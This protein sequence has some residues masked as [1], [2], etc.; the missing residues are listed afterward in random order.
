MDGLRRPEVLEHQA[1]VVPVEEVPEELQD[2]VLVQAVR[3]VQLLQHLQLPDAG[4]AP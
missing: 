3:L 4:F 1:E 2:V